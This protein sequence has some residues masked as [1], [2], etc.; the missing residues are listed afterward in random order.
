MTDTS[1]GKFQAER[2]Q[3]QVL[4]CL[5]ATSAGLRPCVADNSMLANVLFQDAEWH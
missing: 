3:P 5:Y 4:A 1:N 2:V